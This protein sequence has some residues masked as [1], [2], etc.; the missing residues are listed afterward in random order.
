MAKAISGPNK[1][2][3]L[4]LAEDDQFWDFPHPRKK[5]SLKNLGVEATDRAPRAFVPNLAKLMDAEGGPDNLS[6]LGRLIRN[7]DESQLRLLMFVLNS[8]RMLLDV[9]L[10]FGQPV[11]WRS[12]AAYVDGYLDQWWRTVVVSVAQRSDDVIVLAHP[13]EDGRTV[14]IETHRDFILLPSEWKQKKEELENDGRLETPKSMR[15]KSM[16]LWSRDA[17]TTLPSTE[18]VIKSSIPGIEELDLE[19]VKRVTAKQVR[20]AEVKP[21]KTIPGKP[22]PKKPKMPEKRSVKVFRGDVEIT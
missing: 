12:A 10:K 1:L 21:R 3:V 18:D 19:A 15:N 17:K 8:S 6:E 4:F 9:G 22:L 20:E 14:L 13:V 11:F 16:L 2:E 5:E 7:Y